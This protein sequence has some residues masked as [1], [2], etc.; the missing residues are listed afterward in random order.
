MILRVNGKDFSEEEIVVAFRRGDQRIQQA[1]YELCRRH[2]A[3]GTSRYPG[4][5]DYDRSE[6]FQSSFVIFWEKIES[7]QIYVKASEIWVYTRSGERE[8]QNLMAYF[9]KIVKNKFL[10]LC[11]SGQRTFSIEDFP[12]LSDDE[13][14]V[15]TLYWDPDP[16]VEKDRIVS[17]CLLSLPLSCRDILTK[18]YFEKKSLE[19]IL[20]ER[21]ENTSYDGLK[22]RKSKCMANLKKRIK[23]SFKKAG[24]R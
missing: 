15:D 8:I 17:K 10:E 16:E 13:E 14:M 2:F 19:E 18:F 9:M 6:L 21:K 23:E 22:S 4:L 3:I 5:T 12:N 24:L 20:H 7:G 11:R 1:W